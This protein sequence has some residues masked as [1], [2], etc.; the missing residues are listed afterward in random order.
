MESPSGADVVVEDADDETRIGLRQAR[1]GF[2][3][4]YCLI[5]RKQI[6][7]LVIVAG[8]KPYIL[9]AITPTCSYY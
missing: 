9:I 2:A 8:R 5:D 3:S 4:C 1:A 6:R 7:E